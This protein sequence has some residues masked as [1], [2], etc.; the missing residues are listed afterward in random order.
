VFHGLTDNK[1]S[2]FLDQ[3]DAVLEA[4]D[5]RINPPASL[6]T[7]SPPDNDPSAN[8]RNGNGQVGSHRVAKDRT[9]H[10]SLARVNDVVD[11]GVTE[12]ANKV[13][14]TT[15]DVNHDDRDDAHRH[16]VAMIASSTEFIDMVMD[17]LSKGDDQK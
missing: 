16:A 5:G 17:V 1:I 6:A 3:I 8:G 11:E 15:S 12:I 13:D 7:I 10:T 4:I 9:T 2:R 14:E